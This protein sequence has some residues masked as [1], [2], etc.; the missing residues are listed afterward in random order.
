[1][2]AEPAQPSD[3]TV[4]RRAEAL[5]N[6]YM[7]IAIT[8][9]GP[10]RSMKLPW[11]D[12]GVNAAQRQS[13][14]KIAVTGAYS[15]VHADVQSVVS[16]SRQRATARI[17]RF[18]AFG[19][20]LGG[21]LVAA[22]RC[23]ELLREI[24]EEHAAFRIQLEALDIDA[25][26]AEVRRSFQVYAAEIG[27]EHGPEL[28]ARIM[29][30][31][32]RRMPSRQ[33]LLGWDYQPDVEELHFGTNDP[34]RAPLVAATMR[35]HTESLE[36]EVQ[37]AVSKRLL[38]VLGQLAKSGEDP[39]RRVEKHQQ[40]IREAATYADEHNAVLGDPLIE[41]AAAFLS[42]VAAFA[43]VPTRADCAELVSA[44]RAQMELQRA[45]ATMRGDGADGAPL[46]IV[47]TLE[48]A[49][50]EVEPVVVREGQVVVE[51]VTLGLL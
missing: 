40:S 31:V 26:Q 34:E 51:Q 39:T 37:A 33:D 7:R 47:R 32:D 25:L 13:L 29:H 12:L 6:Y 9:S 49:D 46:A 42:S 20:R 44:L 27:A 45:F 17:E 2:Q 21:H 28:E 43:L 41:K 48:V 4:E 35:R 36:R 3:G 38:L 50:T 19:G 15:L 18:A 8:S 14:H 30:E 16:A 5:S 1:M 10:T 23:P 22:W 24:E 11:E